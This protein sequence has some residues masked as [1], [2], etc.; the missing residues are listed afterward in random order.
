MALEPTA[1]VPPVHELPLE[2][3]GQFSR[4]WVRFFQRVSNALTAMSSTAAGGIGSLG[5]AGAVDGSDAA[6]GDIGEYRS[7]TTSGTLAL[8]SGV[9][10]DV[11]TLDL[12]AGDWDVHGWI[13]FQPSAGATVTQFGWGIDGIDTGAPGGAVTAVL[14]GWTGPQRYSVAGG[15]TVVLRA[16][17]DFSGGALTVMGGALRA[18]RMR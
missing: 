8:T 17:C 18:R 1:P 2:A 7:A 6:P 12:T 10:A 15:V 14:G 4:P 5:I 3:D 11:L 16:K 13:G 9:V